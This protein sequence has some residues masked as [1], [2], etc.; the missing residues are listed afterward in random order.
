MLLKNPKSKNPP[1][2]L[3]ANPFS[4]FIPKLQRSS[5]FSTYCIIII[6]YGWP[7]QA[8]PI[9]HLTTPL[10]QILLA[11]APGSRGTVKAWC[12]QGAKNVDGTAL[13]VSAFLC[14]FLWEKVSTKLG[15]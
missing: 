11:F 3:P 14:G 9:Q 8:V 6:T 15:K 10:Q 5:E 4:S 12:R 1:I 13:S 7:G 2:F